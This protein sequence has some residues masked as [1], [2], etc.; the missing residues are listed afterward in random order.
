MDHAAVIPDHHVTQLP[1]MAEDILNVLAMR[2]EVAQYGLAFGHAQTLY[3]RG[4]GRADIERLASRDG[5]RFDHRMQVT[6][7]HL[8]DLDIAVVCDDVV[9]QRGGHRRIHV[10]PGLQTIQILLHALRQRVIRRGHA[11]PA[12]IAPKRWQDLRVR[13]GDDRRAGEKTFVV[14]PHIGPITQLGIDDRNL[15]E[16]LAQIRVKGMHFRLAKILRD[17]QML[18]R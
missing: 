8:D 2:M 6:P 5:M 11:D 10:V 12:G 17:R 7:V 18:G 14:M 9:A 4:V 16:S 1:A 15:L 3:M 13:H